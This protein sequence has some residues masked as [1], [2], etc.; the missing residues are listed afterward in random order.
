[1]YGIFEST[2]NKL[3]G[4]CSD[5]DKADLY[6]ATENLEWDYDH[7]YVEKIDSLDDDVVKCEN[8][9][10][11][12][13]N[14]VFNLPIFS[15]SNPG[16]KETFHISELEIIERRDSYYPYFG[17]ERPITIKTFSSCILISLTANNYDLAVEEA[18]KIIKD[19]ISDENDL[20]TFKT[21]SKNIN[22]WN[23]KK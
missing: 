8:R 9:L 1:M 11:K 15:D 20:I 19:I 23:D 17:E 7:Y 22:I 16:F 12:Y 13:Y 4:Y 3:I 5:R 2:E 14:L 21:I 10:K 18:S 6:V